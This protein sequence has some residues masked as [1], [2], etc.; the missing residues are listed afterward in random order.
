MCALLLSNAPAQV[1]EKESTLELPDC[2][3]QLQALGVKGTGRA[4]WNISVWGAVS[5]HRAV[6][7]PA[8]PSQH[9]EAALPLPGGGLVW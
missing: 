6:G 5:C 9:P 4:E 3:E 1:R 2:A 8:G 7:G